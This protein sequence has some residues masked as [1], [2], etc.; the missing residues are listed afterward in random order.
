MKS[1]RRHELQHNELAEWLFKAG[2]QL[3]PYQNLILAAV[4]V[5]VVR[6]GGLFVVV[7]HGRHDRRPRLGL[8]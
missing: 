3:K 5:L 7:S 4:V 1:E 8:N 6:C 2:E